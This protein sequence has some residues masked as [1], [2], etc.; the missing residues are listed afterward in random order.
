MTAVKNKE[1]RGEG[2]PGIPNTN[3][4]LLIFNILNNSV[5]MRRKKKK[6]VSNQDL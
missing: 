2:G 6:T 4:D 1:G 5:H 3:V